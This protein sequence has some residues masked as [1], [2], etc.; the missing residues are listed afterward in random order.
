MDS[1]L[2]LVKL[3]YLPFQFALYCWLCAWLKFCFVLFY[4]IMEI[5]FLLSGNV[6]Y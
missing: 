3:M 5:I 2:Y 1:L 6:V 4:L